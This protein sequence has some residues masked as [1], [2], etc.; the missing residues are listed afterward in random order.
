M[1]KKVT[2][3]RNGEIRII[4]LRQMSHDR[5]AVVGEKLKYGSGKRWTVLAVEA[6]Q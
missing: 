1:T 3:E 6:L 4:A 2:I 5:Q